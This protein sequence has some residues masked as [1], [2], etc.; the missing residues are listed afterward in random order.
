M[1]VFSY[2]KLGVYQKSRDY[3]KF[4]Y[5]LLRKFPKE[6]QYA[7]CDQ[8]RRTVVSVSSNLAEGSSRYSKKE[9][10]HFVE[11][12][13]GSL[14]E[15]MSQLELSMDLAYITQE[16]L[17]AAESKSEEI[18]RM[19]NSLRHSL[20]STPSTSSTLSTPSTLSTS[21]TPKQ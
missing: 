18:A 20:L 4:V 16:E 5:G 10:A 2:R 1:D 8:L 14:M 7:L 17:T 19:L 6:E 15:V 13:Y 11:I 3:V 12:S 21:S 9:F